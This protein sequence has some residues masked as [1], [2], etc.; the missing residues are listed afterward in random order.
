MDA[1]DD[2]CFA[3]LDLLLGVTPTGSSAQGGGTRDTHDN[4]Q[5]S[6]DH[7]SRRHPATNFSQ[8]S[9]HAFCKLGAP[10]RGVI[11]VVQKRRDR[12]GAP[13]VDIRVT[14][15]GW[16]LIVRSRRGGGKE[17]SESSPRTR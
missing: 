9:V 14:E 17:Q 16:G 7:T 11:T 15:I 1:T 4:E 12:D 10:A 3:C 2:C 13:E 6:R 5:E 8:T